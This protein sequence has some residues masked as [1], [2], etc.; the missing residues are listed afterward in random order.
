MKQSIVYP[1]CVSFLVLF[2]SNGC[3]E[4]G[5]Q[6]HV[7]ATSKTVTAESVAP[8][9]APQKAGLFEKMINAVKH[10]LGALSAKKEAES[11]K[12]EEGASA[13]RHYH[14][15]IKSEEDEET[16]ET[17]TNEATGDE[18]TEPVYED[19]NEVA[20]PSEEVV[21]E[22]EESATTETRSE[23]FRPQ[24]VQHRASDND[25]KEEGG[26]VDRVARILKAKMAAEQKSTTVPS[27]ETV[28]LHPEAKHASPISK[29]ASKPESTHT[30]SAS[31]DR[32]KRAEVKASTKSLPKSQ[33]T[34]ARSVSATA[35][36]TSAKRLLDRSV[37]LRFMPV[38]KTYVKFGTSE[39]HGHVIYMD[40]GEEVPLYKPT[41]YLVPK[42]A[43]AA[44][45]YND[46]YLKN[47]TPQKPLTLIYVN[48]TGLDF[49]NNFSLYG[50]EKG[51]YY[52][53]IV[54]KDPKELNHTVYV[55][56]DLHVD[57][58]KKLIAVFSKALH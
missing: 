38:D 25:E 57:R 22:D 6:L 58:Y 34:S 13:D 51:D 41:A 7:N 18:D 17:S 1:L 30:P 8:V 52:V 3:V 54:A 53:V 31:S 40:H 42:S 20:L 50:V 56:K 4:R 11:A 33:K 45:W 35:M 28:A 23:A 21:S 29:P 44:R 9:G 48:K 26:D 12:Q 19:E 43:I 5:Y 55:A 49:D 24:T 16:V 10:S 36:A 15:R 39:I 32:V 2:L 47:K 27:A 37:A 14:G 46:Y